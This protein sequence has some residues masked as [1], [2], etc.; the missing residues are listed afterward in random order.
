VPAP[1]SDALACARPLLQIWLQ[2]AEEEL[3]AEAE[4]APP[5]PGGAMPATPGGALS[6]A[7]G[8]LL[9]FAERHRR[10][11]N[12]L[13]RSQPSLLESGFAPLL[14]CPRLL[15]FDNKRAL[16]RS[17]LR[18]AAQAERAPALR[19]VVRRP[20]VLTDSYQQLHLRSGAE[21]RGRLTVQFQGEEGVDAGGV[22]RE[23]FTILSRAMFDPSFA[24]FVPSE[25][26]DAVF[27]PNKDSAINPEHLSYFTFCGRVVGKALTDGQLLDAYFTRSFYK[28]I[29]GQPVGYEDIEAADPDYYAALKWMLE[30]DIEGVLD[31]TFVAEEEYFGARHVVEL[32]EGGA[33]RAVTEDNKREYVQL[34]TAHRMTGAIRAQTE[35]FTRGFHD[36]V[37]RNLISMFNSSELELLISGLPEI[38]ADDL[39]ANTDYTGYTATSPIIAWFWSV[40]RAFSREDLARL[41]MFVTGS[42]KVPLGGFAALQGLSGPQKFQIHRA[43]GDASRLPSAHTCFC[44]LD[45]PEYASQEE[46]RAKLT[47]SLHLGGE[48]FGF[49]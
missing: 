22:S 24:L 11:L 43:Y 12:A 38:D 49:A 36:L 20:H 19:V 31:L 5:P 14:R 6:G 1:L 45:L 35:A 40:V 33:S 10:S 37:P 8:A 41:V 30:N 27:Q 28:H 21:L 25:G 23:W 9:R 46:L 48:G 34:I 17:R 15:D 3:P 42:S 47:L 2:L 18:A 32:V 13:V 44:Q 26:R 39:A 16:L 7:M 4:A 29:L